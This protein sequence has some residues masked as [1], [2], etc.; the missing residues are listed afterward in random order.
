MFFG[1]STGLSGFIPHDGATPSA[2]HVFSYLGDRDGFAIDFVAQTMRIN[3]AANPVNNFIG[4]PET[5]LTNWGS[6]GF[7]LDPVKGLEISAARDFSVAL[8]TSLFPYNP[9]ACTVY[10]KYRLNSANS[11][12]Q[13]YLVMADNAGTDRF[14]T[15]A[16]SGQSFRFVSGDGTTADIGLSTLTGAADTEYTAVFGV[17]ENGK[18]FIDDAGIHIDN[19]STLSASTPSHFG[20]GGYPDRVL[21]VLD[22]HIAEIM[23]VC[24]PVP[25]EERLVLTP[26]NQPEGPVVTPELRVFDVLGTRDG[27]AIDFVAGQMKINDLATPANN[28]LGDP[29]SKLTSFGADGFDYDP[30]RGLNI[31]ASRDF[32]AALSTAL[33]PFNPAACTVYAK[34]RVNASTSADQR[35]L[36]MTDNAGTDRFA[37]YSVSGQPFRFVTGD[38]TTADIVLSDMDFSA[39]TEHTI[40]FGAD[41]NHKT[42]IDENGVQTDTGTSI[43]TSQP[44]FVGIGG[45]NDRVLRV[46]D[47]YI[48]EIAVI[49]EPVQREARLTL[50]PFYTIYKAEGDSHTYN[51]N[52]ATWGV[53]V[54]QFYAQRVADSLGPRVLAANFGWS[55]DSS[56]EMVYQLPDFFVDGRPDIAT[57]YAGAND[58]QISLIDET[59]PTATQF[60]VRYIYRTRLEPGGF[61][62]INGEQAR[63]AARDDNLITLEAPLSV[64]PS[65]GDT[66]A[67]DTQANIEYWIDEVRAK[68]VTK[69]A[70][71]GYHFMNFATGGDTP[72]VQHNSRKK[73]RDKQLAAATSRN[74]PYIDTYAHMAGKITSGEVALGDDLSWHVDLGNTHLN[75]AG[76]QAVADAVYDAFV[77]LGWD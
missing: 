43:A 58:G 69:I 18:T 1:L 4:R 75:V 20:I 54:N 73:I 72:T 35:Y 65:V 44:A 45:Y 32:S 70:V 28:F 2:P 39:D 10:V 25:K 62:I 51:T 68:G 5:K 14:A 6:D 53:G 50:D 29:E 16:V 19:A 46:L 52:E 7:I 60:S 41:H 57:I 67:P 15:Y 33:F 31:D 56:S 42:Y 9:Q 49:T 30:V 77:S 48:T 11:S 40:V 12:A 22:G 47:G 24:E 21:R 17:D 26:P 74:V 76:E 3:D 36:F 61:V 55:G 59:V 37:L 34:Y 64:V 8:D 23:V 38:G 63:V 27:F 66:I 13:R 71:I